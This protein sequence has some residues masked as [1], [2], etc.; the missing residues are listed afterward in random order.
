MNNSL[1]IAEAGVNHNGDVGRALEMIDVAAEAGA[2]FVK[3]QTFRSE[4]VVSGLAPKAAY[5]VATT[6]AHESQ[7][8][9]VR[10]FELDLSAHEKLVE[11]C[12]QRGIQFLSTPFDIESANFLVNDL[13]VSSIKVPSGEITN[14]PFL[15][16]LARF[17]RPL[18]VSTGMSTLGEVEEALGVISYAL[19]ARNDLP[20][21]R[22]SFKAAW[23]EKSSIAML[24]E[25]VT[26]LHCTTEYPTPFDEVNLYAMDTLATAFGLPVGFSDHTA[27]IAVPIA[28]AAR[29][30]SVIEKHFTLDRSL[31][32]PDHKASLEP[33]E[34]NAM[35]VSIRQV[36]HALGDGRK[37]PVP[38]EIKNIEIARR[39]LMAAKPV[40]AG[41]LWD[42]DNLTT[43]RPGC[44]RTPFD[45]WEVIGSE[46]ERDYS[47]DELLDL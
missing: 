40:V 9:M 26:L 15:L 4:A 36:E 21:S 25:L 47:V 39:S 13:N 31:P 5:Q 10:K 11:R 44:G 1:I 32:G 33:N 18:L 46:A 24:S 42:V 45:Y 38:S 43:K 23:L 41:E 2:D 29:G 16:K 17:G 34:L 6:G 7:L 28:A 3:F 22:S 35:V 30:A 27:G 14:A 8:E 20:P 12:V 19:G 37:R